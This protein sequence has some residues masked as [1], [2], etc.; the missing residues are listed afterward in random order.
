MNTSARIV[1]TLLSAALLAACG[2]DEPAPAAQPPGAEPKTA[3]GRVVDSALDK[4]REGL[5]KENV[6]LSSSDG[7]PKAEISPEGDLLI[8]GKAVAIDDK[9]RALLLEYRKRIHAVAEAGMAIGT[10]GADLAGKAVGQAFGSIL[11]GDTEQMEKRME[12]EGKKIEAQ[13]LKLCELMPALLD[14]Q[15]ATAESLPAFKPYARMTQKDVDEC[16]TGNAEGR[17]SGAVGQA[18]E[19][20]FNEKVNVKVDIDT[21][22]SDGNNAAEEAEAAGAEAAAEKR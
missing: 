1:T 14:A 21:G 18:I 12:A 3:L 16:R 8:D 7:G 6:G 19:S 15:N 4:A 17:H 11:S 10:Q 20:A 13:A 9:Q 5:A 22:A 2:K